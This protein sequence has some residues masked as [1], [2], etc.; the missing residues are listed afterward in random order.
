M[1][2]ANPSGIDASTSRA[3]PTCSVQVVPAVQISVHHLP[4]RAVFGLSRAVAS[5]PRAR[6]CRVQTRARGETRHA[7]T[8]S[9]RLGLVSGGGPPAPPADLDRAAGPGVLGKVPVQ[10]GPG[11]AAG[12]HQLGDV[13]ALWGSDAQREPQQRARRVPVVVWG[14]TATGLVAGTNRAGRRVWVRLG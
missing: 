12:V 11:H 10:G 3:S 2:S 13:R 4:S 7:A 1:Q 8:G 6:G 14:A 9:P 5:L